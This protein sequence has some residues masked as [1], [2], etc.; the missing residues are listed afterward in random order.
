L[1]TRRYDNVAVVLAEAAQRG[2]RSGEPWEH[3]F[4]YTDVWL[5]GERR[6]LLEGLAWPFAPRSPTGSHTEAA[7]SPGRHPVR[8]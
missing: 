5:A 6:T 8:N 3:T 4:R 1:A 7:P 2:S